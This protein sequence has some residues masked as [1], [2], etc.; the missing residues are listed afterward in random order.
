MSSETPGLPRESGKCEKSVPSAR[1]G[2]PMHSDYARRQ[3]LAATVTFCIGVAVITLA[4]PLLG[5]SLGIGRPFPEDM[6]SFRTLAA[7]VAAATILYLL[8]RRYDGD[9]RA[10]IVVSLG[11]FGISEVVSFAAAAGARAPFPSYAVLFGIAAGVYAM[12]A[13]FASAA[14]PPTPCDSSRPALVAAAVS[15]CA[16]S[17]SGA[18]AAMT[19]NR[20]FRITQNYLS[21]ILLGAAFIHAALR[22]LGPFGRIAPS[23]ERSREEGEARAATPPS[24]DG[25]A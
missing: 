9:F 1:A 10:L 8:I 15:I 20:E 18:M 12:L 6:R 13:L 23:A 16:V 7:I 11:L 24:D 21:L 2:D 4:R 17:F 22:L 19:G 14:C 3:V 25:A 5:A